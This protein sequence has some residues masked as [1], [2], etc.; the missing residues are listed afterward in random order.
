[1]HQHAREAVRSLSHLYLTTGPRDPKNELAKQNNRFNNW[2]T[3]VFFHK[4]QQ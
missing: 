2:R 3:D 4:E 1:M